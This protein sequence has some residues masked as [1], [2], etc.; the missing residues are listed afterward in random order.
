MHHTHGQIGITHPHLGFA[1]HVQGCI[2]KVGFPTPSLS[3]PPPQKKVIQVSVNLV[4]EF[5]ILWKSIV[6][7]RSTPVLYHS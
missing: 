6:T 1:I 7:G 4:L 3:Y 5:D 2:Q